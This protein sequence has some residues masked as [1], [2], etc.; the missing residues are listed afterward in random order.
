MTRGLEI[1]VLDVVNVRSL[2][3]SGCESFY[4]GPLH[5]MHGWGLSMGSIPGTSHRSTHELLRQTVE[6]GDMEHCSG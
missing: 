5:W 6:K 3:G 4:R 1:R 2:A